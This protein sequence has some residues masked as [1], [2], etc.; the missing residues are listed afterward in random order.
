MK[1]RKYFSLYL[2]FFKIG[3]MTFGGGL[4]M[5]P[6][7][8]RETVDKH[9]Y[10]TEEEILDYYAIGQC[11]PGIIAVNCATFIGNKEAGFLGA[12]AATLGVITPSVIIIIIIAAL[13]DQFMDNSY[14]LHALSGIR[15]IVCALV[16]NSVI[17]MARKSMKDLAA[18]FV[19]SFALFLGLFTPLPTVIT[20]ILGAVSG[21]VIKVLQEKYKDREPVGI[22]PE[23]WDKEDRK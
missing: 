22:R 5:L 17:S 4:A 7:L 8:K 1:I 19:F 9:G 12:L 6:M 16:L 20:V 3:I 15:I 10:V 18:V 13:L 2:S 21:I 11:T 14:V 23:G